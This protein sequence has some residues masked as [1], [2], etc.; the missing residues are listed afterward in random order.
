MIFILI[1]GHLFNFFFNMPNNYSVI[2]IKNQ[3]KSWFDW[4]IFK[5][6]KF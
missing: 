2:Q 4:L 3:L 6:K 5:I 1:T